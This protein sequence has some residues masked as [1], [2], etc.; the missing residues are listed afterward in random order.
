MSQTKKKAAKDGFKSYVRSAQ[1]AFKTNDYTSAL[2]FCH[3]AL[4]KKDEGE[5]Q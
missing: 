4:G 5:W 3:R 2:K 1:K